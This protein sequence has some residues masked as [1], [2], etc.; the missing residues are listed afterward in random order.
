V[1]FLANVATCG[2][3]DRRSDDPETAGGRCDVE[4]PM[5]LRTS[6][7]LARAAA[8]LLLAGFL[9]GCSDAGLDD[10]DLVSSLQA[11]LA[12]NG[13]QADDLRCPTGLRAAVGESVRCTFTVG[14]QPVD[15]VARIT[16]VDG[17]T[18]TYDVHTEPRPVMQEVLERSVAE[19]L[20][21]AGVPAGTASC[22]G[23]LPAQVG[24]TVGCTLSGPEGVS[25]WTVRTTSV[26]GGK[27]DYSIEQAGLS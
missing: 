4:E 22:A 12:R 10:D 26:D 19:K 7:S 23:D 11:E 16:A 27:I 2:N 17:E 1:P 24:S 6:R 3:E 20:A 18:V 5:A 9:A 14:G 15:A 21:Q 25:E 8:A 13:V